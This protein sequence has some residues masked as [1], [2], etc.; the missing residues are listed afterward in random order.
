[1]R[2]LAPPVGFSRTPGDGSRPGPALGADT[3]AVLRALGY[4][5]AEIA[6]LLE[7][8]VVAGPQDVQAGSFR[9]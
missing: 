9:A 1:M 6:R 2:L 5:P 4:A 7:Q 8:G 3:E